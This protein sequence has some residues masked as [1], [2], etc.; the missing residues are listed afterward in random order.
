MSIGALTDKQRL[1]TGRQVA[2]VLGKSL[3]LWSEF[4]RFAEED[5]HANGD[6]RFYG[7]NYG[8]ALRFRKTGKALVSLYPAADSFGVQIILPEAIVKQAMKLGKEVN[9]AIRRATPY[10]E[11]RWIFLRVNSKRTADDGRRLLL[12]KVGQSSRVMVTVPSSRRSAEK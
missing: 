5:F 7:K 11:G 12:L 6:W 9:E 4:V 3:E 2:R 10:P 1:P 8:W